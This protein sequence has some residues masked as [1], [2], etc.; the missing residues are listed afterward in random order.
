MSSPVRASVRKFSLQ[1][2]PLAVTLVGVLA[3]R[4]AVAEPYVV[5][6]GS[7]EPTIL[8]GDRLLVWKAAYDWRIPFSTQ[9]LH[10][11]HDPR[12]GDV[13][14]FRYPGEPSTFYIKRLIGVPGD[15]VEVADG[16]IR[17]NGQEVP[18]DKAV[19]SVD[20]IWRREHLGDKSYDVQRL[21]H[22]QSSQ[23]QI[24]AVPAQ[25]YFFMGDNRDN[26]NDSRFWGFVPAEYIQG[27]ALG[28][29]LSFAE[30]PRLRWERIGKGL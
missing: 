5:P 8:P 10:R 15:Q 28:V 26:S 19:P 3:F 24:F 21:P 9:S 29:W 17:I 7:M 16:R 18:E 25:S 27:K 11:A 6:S 13:V 12:R 23:V 20:G 22:A 1:A 30:F 2:L 14:V 4:S